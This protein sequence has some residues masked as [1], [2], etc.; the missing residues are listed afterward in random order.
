MNLPA[1]RE[2]VFSHVGTTDQYAGLR[3][4]HDSLVAAE[5]IDGCDNKVAALRQLKTNVGSKR[6]FE[7]KTLDG[8]PEP[9]SFPRLLSVHAEIDHIYQDLGVALRLHVAAHNT[10]RE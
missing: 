7:R 5:S 9:G 3:V 8:M 10:K 2:A 6:G 4:D 1:Y